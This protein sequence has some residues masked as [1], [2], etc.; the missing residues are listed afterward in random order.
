MRRLSLIAVAAAVAVAPLAG[1]ANGAA[2]EPSKPVRPA[3]GAAASTPPVIQWLPGTD[4]AATGLVHYPTGF[5]ARVTRRVGSPVRRADARVADARSAPQPAARP[6]LAA[7]DVP[8]ADRARIS[9]RVFDT[10]HHPLAGVEINGYAER[11]AVRHDNRR[12]RPL[13]ARHRAGQLLPVRRWRNASG[14]NADAT[15][16]VATAE[17]VQLDPGQH[18]IRNA[19]LRPGAALTVRVT[20]RAGR[21]LAGAA[22]YLEPVAPYVQTDTGSGGGGVSYLIEDRTGPDGTFTFRGLPSDAVFVCFSAYGV[23]I[24]GGAHDNEGYRDRCS[25]PSGR[26][27]TADVGRTPGRPAWFARRRGAARRRDRGRWPA[28]RRRRR[29]S[30]ERPAFRRRDRHR[31]RRIVQDHRDPPRLVSRV[32]PARPTAPTHRAFGYARQLPAGARSP[33]ARDHLATADVHLHR[34]GAVTGDRDRPGGSPVPGRRRSC[35]RARVQDL[36]QDVTDGQGRVPPYRR[37]DR[38]VPGLRSRRSTRSTRT[39]RPATGPGATATAR[40]WPSGRARPAAASTFSSGPAVL[41][42]AGWSTATAPASAM[43]MS[44]WT[45]SRVTSSPPTQPPTPTATTGSPGC[46][47]ASTTRASTTSAAPISSSSAPARATR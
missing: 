43:S 35:S 21:P 33:C 26:A 3:V 41:S 22:P 27:R 10:E 16:Y 47:P 17:N 37:V 8:A 20:D 36:P 18:L 24:S 42:S 25:A 5:T 31:S 12:Q 32:R 30:G 11:N 15:G 6:A 1:P 38:R 45:T 29:G 13:R 19:K 9:G 2:A 14:G 23:A 28:A 34:G 4:G 39:A 40:R 7:A 44:N 46:R